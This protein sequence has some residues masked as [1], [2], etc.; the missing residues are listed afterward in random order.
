MGFE[1]NKENLKGSALKAVELSIKA[2]DKDNNGLSAEEI[3]VFATE[4]KKYKDAKWIKNKEYNQVIDSLNIK[5]D[6][7]PVKEEKA[8]ETSAVTKE[9][10]QTKKDKKEAGTDVKRHEKTG[11]EHLEIIATTG[12]S[13]DDIITELN[14]RLGTLKDEKDF[15]ELKENIQTV[16]DKSKNYEYKTFE[17]IEKNAKEIKKALKNDIDKNL[18][19]DIIDTVNAS[20]K[21]E[22]VTEVYINVIDIHNQLKVDYIKRAEKFNLDALSNGVINRMLADGFIAKDDVTKDEKG[23]LSLKGNSKYVEA[24]K[25]YEIE[26]LMVKAGETWFDSLV[27]QDIETKKGKVK[28]DT[29]RQLK[30]EGK[31]DS[32]VKDYANSKFGD[33]ISGRAK[34]KNLDSEIKARFNNIEKLS[35]QTKDEIL[36]TLGKKSIV[37]DALVGQNLITLRKDG[38]YDISKLQAELL[39]QIGADAR[40]NRHATIDEAIG[41]FKAALSKSQE[42]TK[43]NNL[44]EKELKDLF[45]LCGFPTESKV[46][47]GD[48]MKGLAEGLLAGA[49]IG[50]GAFALTPISVDPTPLDVTVDVNLIG[51]NKLAGHS[52]PEDLVGA[53]IETETGVTVNIKGLI[54]GVSG[55]A[56]LLKYIGPVAYKAALIGGAIGLLGALTGNGKGE[57]PITRLKTEEETLEQY[58][59]RVKRENPEYAEV[60]EMLAKTFIQ[61]DGTWNRTGYRDFLDTIAGS[62][63]LNRD[64]LRGILIK[65]KENLANTP[66][67][68]KQDDQGGEE[69]PEAKIDKK[70]GPNTEI[71]TD[72]THIHRRK[73]GDSWAGLVEAYYPGL[74]EACNGKM[75]GKDGA[76]RALQTALATD[77]EGNLDTEKLQKLYTATDLPKEI[78]MPTKVKEIDR[79]IGNVKAIKIENDGKGKYIA[80]LDKVG[81]D[82]LTTIKQVGPTTYIAMD[83]ST[84]ATG[85]GSSKKEALDELKKV[86]LV[87]KYANEADLL[88]E[89][90]EE[91][92]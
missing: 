46:H 20:I 35:V 55:L 21:S 75:Y 13:R 73:Y 66:V 59:E 8:E 37:F 3:S 26:V 86:T 47:F 24:L 10:L 57:V 64:E 4:L 52:I 30:D 56:N 44:S 60:F 33:D 81:R 78:K 53:V 11:S 72:H 1:I 36:N 34:V 15:K 83:L 62:D 29:I 65:Y 82:E 70:E 42:L 43:L 89:E 17:D 87:D 79:V 74:V 49:V 41:E 63:K 69:A 51:G 31:Y 67:V 22:L 5:A 48:V 16:I 14:N 77:K 27:D 25:R 7:T 92:K 88:K 6:T 40:V 50:A 28:K 38:S 61:E 12:V 71:T 45:K 90:E 54:G 76:I 80:P 2:A 39:K 19:N 32:Y 23:N 18:L 58:V 84:K 91:S 85:S 9:E 68:K